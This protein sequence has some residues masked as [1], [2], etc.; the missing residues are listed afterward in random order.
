MEDAP[1]LAE[2]DSEDE[3]LEVMVPLTSSMVK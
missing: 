3:Q 2:P 1:S